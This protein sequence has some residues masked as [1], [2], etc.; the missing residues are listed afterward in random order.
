MTSIRRR[1]VALSTAAA[2]ACVAAAPEFAVAVDTPNPSPPPAPAAAR[3][4]VKKASVKR[5]SVK[6]AG[7]KKKKRKRVAKRQQTSELFL[8]GYRT[9]H[10]LIYQKGD[11]AGGITALKALGQ[12]QHA[13]VANLIGFASRKLGRYDDAKV[14]YEKALASDPDHTRTWSYYG[15][16][17]A[18]HGNRLKAEDFLQ[19][20]A[21]LCGNT[22]CREYTELKG[23]IDGT[24]TY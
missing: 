4:G 9:A 3:I 18:E 15:M 7:V 23:V 21:S 20:V 19:K 11:Y 22:T 10:A 24:A 8:E 14:W 1:V 13:D 12:D 2:F 16:W 17:H 5:P 6:K